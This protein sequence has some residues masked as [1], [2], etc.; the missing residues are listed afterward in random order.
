MLQVFSFLFFSVNSRC[1]DVYLLLQNIGF[2]IPENNNA[3]IQKLDKDEQDNKLNEIDNCY[4]SKEDYVLK[5]E[6]LYNNVYIA[7]LVFKIFSFRDA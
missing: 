5:N 6:K 7:N 4:I 3:I 2:P 1:Q